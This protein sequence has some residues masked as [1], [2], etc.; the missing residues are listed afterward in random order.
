MAAIIVAAV[1]RGVSAVL[2]TR[3]LSTGDYGRQWGITVLG[4]I[5]RGG[6]HDDD[7]TTVVVLNK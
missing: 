1:V 3:E 6:R 4:N 5:G 2:R 7:V